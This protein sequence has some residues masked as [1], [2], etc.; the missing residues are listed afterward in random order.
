MV[1]LTSFVNIVAS[2]LIYSMQNFH[3]QVLIY[4]NLSMVNVATYIQHTSSLV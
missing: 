2:K 1:P 4:L 3:L